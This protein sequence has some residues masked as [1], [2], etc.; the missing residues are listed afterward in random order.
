MT[1]SIYIQPISTVTGPQAVEGDAVRL[2]GS[3]AYAREF[4]VIT[5]EGGKVVDRQLATS[6]SIADLLGGLPDDLAAEGE[7]QWSNLSTVHEPLQCG[8]RVIRL[9]APQIMG[10]LNVTPDSF[11]DGGK[12]MD[13]PLAMQDQAA[14]MHEAGAAIIDIGGEST[15]PGA[16][17]VW[18]GDEIKRVIP[19]IEYCKGMGAAVSVDTRRPAVM[20]AALDAGAAIINDVSALR[21][22][23]RSLEFAASSG[24]PVILMHAPGP[25]NEAAEDLH[26]NADYTAVAFDVFDW[27]KERRDAALAAGIARHNI[28]LDPGVGFGKSVADNLNLLN[29]LPLFH[30]LGQPLLLGASRKRMIGAL[31]NEAGSN[32]RLGGSIVLAQLGMDAGYHLLRVHDVFETV[33]ARNVWRGLRDAGVTDFTGLPG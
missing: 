11:S 18:E 25:S 1:Q 32:K 28:V 23:P 9:D 24:K 7:A 19:A 14:D 27:L 16:A 26:S 2:G 21:H 5:R 15:R 3:M 13:D 6:R 10:I 8:E 17:A 4:A 12:F 29:A 22:D 20:Q 31:S 30:A 33:Q